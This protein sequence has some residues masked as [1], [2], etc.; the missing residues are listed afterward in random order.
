MSLVFAGGRVPL[1]TVL[2]TFCGLGADQERALSCPLGL[3]KDAISLVAGIGGPPAARR[4]E[5]A[6]RPR[7]VGPRPTLPPPHRSRIRLVRGAGQRVG[8]GGS[9]HGRPRRT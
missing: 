6:P 3:P 9:R 8:T 4:S 1:L 7:G 5:G 2:R